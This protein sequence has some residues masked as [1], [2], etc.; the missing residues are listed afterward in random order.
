MRKLSTFLFICLV[1]VATATVATSLDPSVQQG[2]NL[3]N[4]AQE[5]RDK[6]QT[7]EELNAALHKFDEAIAIFEK[8]RA[9]KEKA[10]ALSGIASAYGKFNENTKAIEFNT[11][12]LDIYQ[13]LGDRK[14][15]AST[16]KTIGMRY[17]HMNQYERAF[18][19]YEKALEVT[20]AF[21]DKAR[22]VD[23][24]NDLA[25]AYQ[26]SGRDSKAIELYQRALS[27]LQASKG[28]DTAEDLDRKANQLMHLH[29][30]DE[31]RQ[32]LDQALKIHTEK[33]NSFGASLVLNKIASTYN[34][35]GNYGKAEQ[36][37]LQVL[38]FREQRKDF[39]G[40]F[41]TMA[42][43]A[44]VHEE[45]GDYD[46]ALAWYG[47]QLALAREKGDLQKELNVLSARGFLFGKWGKNDM[48]FES[49]QRANEIAVRLGN[50]KGEALTLGQLGMSSAGMGLY[51]NA[52]GYYQR[53]L[54]ILRKIGDRKGEAIALRMVALNQMRKGEY[55]K[56]MENLHEAYAISEGVQNASDM[57]A[58]LNLIGDLH[59]H[60]GHYKEAEQAYRKA[61]MVQK[62]NGLFSGQLY[63]ARLMSSLY[64]SWGQVQRAEQLLNESQQIG[65]QLGF[66]S[67]KKRH[68]ADLLSD[69]GKI[70]AVAGRYPEAL[71][72]FRQALD[73][74][75]ADVQYTDS[76]RLQM[77]DIYMDM[78]ELDEAYKILSS[79]DKPLH[80]GRL[81]LLR[82]DYPAAIKCYTEVLEFGNRSGNVDSLF[83][84]HTGL[85]R[86]FEETDDYAQ[87]ERHYRLAIDM[88][89]EI[90]SSLLPSERLTFFEAR[91][92]GFRRY[93]PARGLTRVLLKQQRYIESIESG[94]ITKAR[95]FSDHIA[96][97]SE[98]SDIPGELR[99]K[100]EALV[101]TVASLRKR[102]HEISKS[103]SPE[104]YNMLVREIEAKQQELNAFIDMLWVEHRAYAAA[105]YPKPIALKNVPLNPGEHAI[106]LDVLDRGIGVHL[107]IGPLV[108]SS[109]FVPWDRT[110]MAAQVSAFRK[111]FETANLR[112]FDP[113][114]GAAILD[115]LLRHT[116]AGISSGQPITIIPDGELSLLPFEVLVVKG[117]GQWQ[118]GKWGDFPAQLNY[119]G[120]H[121]PINY[122]HS[123]TSLA[124]S[125][126][127]GKRDK[128]GSR[129]LVVADPVFDMKEKRA[130]AAPQI[131]LSAYD[132][133]FYFNLMA[134]I[135]GTSGLGLRFERLPQTGQLARDLQDVYGDRV[136]VLT[137]LDATKDQIM[138]KLAGR[139]DRYSWIVFATHGL[140]NER[141]PG[142]CEPF[143]ALSM[144]PPGTDGF[145]RMSDIMSLR[146]NA[147]VVALTACQTGMGS[148]VS[149]EGIL[150]MGRSFQYAGAEAVLTSL[151]SVAETSSVTLTTEFFK[152]L[153]TGKPAREALSRA[154][155][156]IRSLGFEHPFF[157]AAFVLVGQNN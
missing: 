12:S 147:D 149:G 94:E 137:G 81:S 83:S 67:L 120:D 2:K 9:E 30:W 72:N 150:S 47:R 1:Q 126:T 117:E 70:H 43:I 69:M 34:Y 127:V 55:T 51:E 14:W 153:K 107:L 144:V 16:L 3:R 75:R 115:R 33:G 108:Q 99:D 46:K 151:W 93:E 91:I 15:E 84:G 56:A 156:T 102:K 132:R 53:E 38:A 23:V 79:M 59:R 7:R 97:R 90:R 4:Q 113:K 80:Q 118:K 85:G 29:E 39:D 105:R 65:Q 131:Q 26:A 31:A 98:R 143:L 73:I 5:L 136:D 66:F 82:K 104:T 88:S 129:L 45:S 64:L 124:L 57:A 63:T 112:E 27:L 154:R 135:E 111:G 28:K 60:R 89:E 11:A 140:A 96:Q 110:E 40:Q 101:T 25:R 106:V 155:K 138:N 77:A 58:N 128:R 22:E 109:V 114:L 10:F 100:E 148:R 49:F 86:A 133:D 139:L 145:L 152:E 141:I 8:C 116:L 92:G 134:T 44:H 35:Q 20:Q 103:E 17:T 130:Q 6:A 18:Q 68:E 157:W 21:G 48:A 41:H 13:R 142:I 146:L 52:L 74:H 62:E 121:H 119:L 78:G 42:S 76:V 61:L 95:A 50:F 19:F 123:L 37:Y 24:L 122:Y 125:R 54:A 87:A 71:E 36:S 32:M